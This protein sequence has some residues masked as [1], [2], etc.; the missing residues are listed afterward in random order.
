[1][2]N[3]SV[4]PQIRAECTDYFHCRFGHDGCKE[5]VLWGWIVANQVLLSFGLLPE[6]NVQTLRELPFDGTFIDSDRRVTTDYI[7]AQ[8]T[9]SMVEEMLNER[10]VDG[11]I[12]LME[13]AVGTVYK[14]LMEN[15][16]EAVGR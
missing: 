7:R 4:G 8:T 3:T 9:R 2:S 5:T 1:M 12:K 14:E 13:R 15:T 10:G 6:A 16:N 11:T